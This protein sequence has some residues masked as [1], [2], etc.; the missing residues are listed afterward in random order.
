MNESQ[1][2]N[3]PAP[4]PSWDYFTVWGQVQTAK[5]QL[6][7]LLEYLSKIEEASPSL[8][9]IVEQRLAEALVKLLDAYNF[10]PSKKLE[11]SRK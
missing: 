5:S 9:L 3:Y 6:E 2:L 8:D 1:Q 4:D 11:S 10:M 7:S